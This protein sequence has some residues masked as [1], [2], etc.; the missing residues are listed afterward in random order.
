MSAAG[1]VTATC[2]SWSRT[3]VTLLVAA[4]ILAAGPAGASES[5][6]ITVRVTPRAILSAIPE[7]RAGSPEFFKICQDQTYA[8]CA[9]ASCYVYNQVAYCACDIEHG[10]S[11]SLPFEVDGEDV[12][13]VNANGAGNGYMVSLYSV[14]EE[15]LEGGDVALYTCP[16]G[17]VG[18]RLRPVRRRLLLHQLRGQPHFRASTSHWP[19]TRS[20]AH[21]RSP[22][23]I[24][25]A[26]TSAT[27]SP[28][29]IPA[30]P[31][32]LRTARAATPTRRPGPSCRSAR[33]PARR[34][35]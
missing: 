7:L 2:A 14:P 22:W 16:A 13:D 30:N 24:P 3:R 27:R 23:P 29:P 35:S 8:L 33:R 18:R 6:G 26:P 34:A 28:A 20:S 25:T 31:T 4:L 15:G 11:I 19:R 32:T 21:A 12:C 9:V 5:D 10:D 1:N 17:S